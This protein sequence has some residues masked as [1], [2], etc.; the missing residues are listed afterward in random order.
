VSAFSKGTYVLRVTTSL[1]TKTEKVV[2]R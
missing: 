2:V 1:G